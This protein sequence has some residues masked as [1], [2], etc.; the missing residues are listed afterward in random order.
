[1]KSFIT[2]LYFTYVSMHIATHK[3]YNNYIDYRV[4]RTIVVIKS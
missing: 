2:S 1:M 4:A 3:T